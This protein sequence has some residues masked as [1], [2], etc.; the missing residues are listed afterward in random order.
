[1]GIVVEVLFVPICNYKL[2]GLYESIKESLS[3][4]YS[5]LIFAFLGERGRKGDTTTQY[6][7][8]S[9]IRKK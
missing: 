1:M 8:V 2:I 6:D 4:L 7:F 5:T 3:E 9:S